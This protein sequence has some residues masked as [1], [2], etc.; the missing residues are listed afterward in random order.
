MTTTI[1]KETISYEK[2]DSYDYSYKP[3]ERVSET[4]M[5]SKYESNIDPDLAADMKMIK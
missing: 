2:P 1:V 3:E 5:Y 4:Y